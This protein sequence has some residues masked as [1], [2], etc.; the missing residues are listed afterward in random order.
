MYCVEM[1]GYRPRDG[2][3]FTAPAHTPTNLPPRT[4]K[5]CETPGIEYDQNAYNSSR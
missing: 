1:N 3:T 4:V 5:N 2:P